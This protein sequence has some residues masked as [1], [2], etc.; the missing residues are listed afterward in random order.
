MIDLNVLCNN[1]TEYNV[2]LITRERIRL[3]SSNAQFKF[4]LFMNA[5]FHCDFR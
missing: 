2:Y 1:K 4:A 5:P 3:L